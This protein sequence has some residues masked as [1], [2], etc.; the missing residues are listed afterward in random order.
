MRWFRRKP[1][2]KTCIVEVEGQR[3]RVGIKPGD[4]PALLLF[5]GIGARLELLEPFTRLLSDVET[6]VFDVPGVGGS[7]LPRRPYRFSRLARLADA[8]LR[9]LGYEGQ[10]DALGVSWGG[11]A[12]QQFAY[13]CRERC[14]RL[15][16]AATTAGAVMV[17]GRLSALSRMLNARRYSEPGYMREIAAEL[18]GGVLRREPERIEAYAEYMKP[19]LRLGYLYQQLAITGWTSL[20]WLPALRQPTLV[21]TGK[22]DP[23]VPPLNGRILSSLIPGARLEVIDD[24]HLFLLTS[25]GLVA[26]MVKQF[27]R[28][29]A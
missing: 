7:P 24:G 18:Y 17:P 20:R 26:P 11:A 6:I 10:L 29:P 13:T 25:A 1:Q 5:N 21:L 12:A 9:V 16:L 23:L 15:V 3:L 2:T 4:H 8:M 19:P 28:A 27:L 22:D 14:R